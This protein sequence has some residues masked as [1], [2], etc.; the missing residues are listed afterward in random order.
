[1]KGGATLSMLVW[2]VC[3]QYHMI[4][5]Q[6]VY[7]CV[8]LTSSRKGIKISHEKEAHSSQGS[9]DMKATTSVASEVTFLASSG[10]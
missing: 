2:F 7:V 3:W 5:G 9:A 6:C 1:M 10:F 8:C 4:S